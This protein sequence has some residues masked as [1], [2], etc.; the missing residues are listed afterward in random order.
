M[1]AIYTRFPAAMNAKMRYRSVTSSGLHLLLHVQWEYK[2]WAKTMC[3][4]TYCVSNCIW[5]H[6]SLVFLFLFLVFFF[7]FFFSLIAEVN[8]ERTNLSPF[9]KGYRGLASFI[10][11]D[12]NAIT[13][14][15]QFLKE[16]PLRKFSLQ[17]FLFYILILLMHV[18]YICVYIYNFI[19]LG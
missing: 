15:L 3:F 18:F 19:K 17:M 7:F 6:F 2:K 14:I 5:L 9:T 13:N 10:Q 8:S 11:C 16:F 12:F 1:S 4:H